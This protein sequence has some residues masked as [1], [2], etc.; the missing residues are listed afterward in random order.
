M[1][2]RASKI[3]HERNGLAKFPSPNRYFTGKQSLDGLDQNCEKQ[4]FLVHFLAADL[5]D[6]NVKRPETL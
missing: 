5:H 3:V 6:Y 1:I 4:H 2:R